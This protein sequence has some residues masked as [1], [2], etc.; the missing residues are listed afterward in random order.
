MAESYPNGQADDLAF[1][2]EA[3]GDLLTPRLAVAMLV[4]VAVLSAALFALLASVPTHERPSHAPFLAAMRPIWSCM[5]RSDWR[6][7]GF[8][9]T[10]RARR[11]GRI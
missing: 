9:T 6:S 4:A 11:G 5:S 7:C 2:K 1:L 10:A 3:I 8:S